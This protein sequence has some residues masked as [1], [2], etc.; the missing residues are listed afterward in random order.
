M[1]QSDN[2]RIPV[3]TS[4]WHPW[5]RW[6]PVAPN[7]WYL[8]LTSLLTDVS[9]EMVS[10]VLPAY[11]VIQ[12]NLSPLAIGAL[13]G[14]SNGVSAV[15]R[16][17]SGVLADRWRRYKEL[18]AVGYLISVLC[19]LGLLLAGRHVPTIA[20]V[21]AADRIGKAIRTVPRDALISLSATRHQLGQAFGVHRA[22]DA[23]G[24]LLGPLCAFVVLMA[25]PGAYDVVFV[26]SFCVAVAGLSVL[27]LFVHNV[28][29]TSGDPIDDRPSLRTAIG[30]LRRP[31]FRLVVI[32]ASGL[33]L[34]TI[35][36]AFIYLALRD[37]MRFASAL[38]P[39]LFVG[40]A[41]FYLMLAIPA[42]WLSD[43][44]G[45][46]RI[47][48]LSHVVLLACY[49]LLLT[50][51]EHTLGL[52][53][54][55][56]FLGAYYAATDG[57]VIALASGTLPAAHRGSGLALLTS[58]ISAARA[59]ASLAF[60]WTWS[61]FGKDT[62][63]VSFIVALSMVIALATVTLGRYEWSADGS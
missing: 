51:P 34:V 6:T 9:S 14:L 56:A 57:V 1:Y 50:S 45:R 52:I 25:L 40:T 13:D 8:G 3:D 5:R 35:G 2:T 24:A 36:D 16:W 12:L 58:A 46:A 27:L 10:S 29:S 19:R 23:I 33:S 63:I 38:F 54:P 42:G 18:A 39:L 30:L 44:V 26:T 55:I 53:V 48:L 20:S 61:V 47:F 22:L 49:A 7:V 62:A 4:S 21:V 11:L 43:R 28:P 41:F 31:D 60:G 15:M 17:I 37:S 59:G 32:A